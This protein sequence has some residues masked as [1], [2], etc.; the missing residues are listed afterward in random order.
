[1]M[2]GVSNWRKIT[3][4][5]AF[6]IFLFNGTLGLLLFL[7]IEVIFG[8]MV[9]LWV[10][11]KGDNDYMLVF[12]LNIGFL[13]S[14]A[15]AVISAYYTSERVKR[16]SSMIAAFLTYGINFLIWIVIAYAYQ[17][18]LTRDLAWTEGA[19]VLPKIITQFATTDLPNAT[20]LWFYAQ[21]TYSFLYALVLVLIKAPVNQNPAYKRKSGG[22]WL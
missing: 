4:K 22:K 7:A 1:M 20:F 10:E 11:S 17:G 5:D 2:R 16:S 13:I 6:S 19:A 8:Q 9:V 12:I 14:A 18:A 15:V 21:I 3:P